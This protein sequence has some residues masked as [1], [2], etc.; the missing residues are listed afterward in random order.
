MGSYG[1]GRW[2]PPRPRSS[3]RVFGR[4]GDYPLHRH[5]IGAL[6]GLGF[7]SRF[8]TPSVD[9]LSLCLDDAD[10]LHM[11]GTIDQKALVKIPEHCLE[12]FARQ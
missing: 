7:F 9:E 6:A 4:S 3:R 8:K 1:G 2:F 12:K 11:K 5:A 10:R